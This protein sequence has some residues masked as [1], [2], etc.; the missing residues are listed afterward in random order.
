MRNLVMLALVFMVACA[1]PTAPELSLEFTWAPQAPLVHQSV[2]FSTDS[3]GPWLW[4]FGDGSSSD[5]KNP[6]HAFG[7]PKAYEVRLMVEHRSVAHFVVV[8][9]I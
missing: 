9:A 7:G 5:L 1:S 3:A 4:T 8:R 6:T 2:Q